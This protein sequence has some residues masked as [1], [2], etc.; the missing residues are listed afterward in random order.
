MFTPNLDCWISKVGDAEHNVYGETEVKK[1][2]RERCAIVRL[3]HEMQNTT[4]RADSSASRGHGN[5]FVSSNKI[6]LT[7]KTTATH[8]D[9]LLVSGVEMRVLSLFPRYDVP[10]RLDHYEVVGELWA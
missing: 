2:V 7:A 10:G 3:R 1:P 8:G 4:V 9:K 5:E 6:L